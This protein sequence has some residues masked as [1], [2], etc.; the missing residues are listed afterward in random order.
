[1]AINWDDVRYRGDARDVN[2]LYEVYRV[3]DYLA[4]FE[5]NL[6]RQDA[7]IREQFLKDGIRLSR[8]L[9][10]RI[11]T[12]YQDLCDRLGTPMDVEIF[13]LPDAAVNAVAILDIQEAGTWSLVGVTAGA[14]EKL[15]DDE[16]KAILGH[17]VGHFLFGNHRLSA[18]RNTDPENPALTVLPVFGESLFL[19]WQKKAEISA[20][21]VGLLAC[22]NLQ[23]AARALLKATFGLS[24]RNINIDILALMTQIDEIRGHPEMMREAFSS[25][26]LLPVRLKA[27][28]SFSRSAKAARNGFPAAADPLDDDALEN[29]TDALVTLSRRYPHKRIG[30]A[31]MRAVALGGVRVLSADGDVS[32]QEIKILISLLYKHFTD[33]PEKEIVT[34]PEKLAQMLPKE[35]TVIREDGDPDDAGFVL[36]RLADVALADGAL[37][38]PEGGVILEIAEQLDFPVRSAYGILMQAAQEVG[39]QVDQKL[40]RLADQLKQSLTLDRPLPGK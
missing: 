37:L 21:R 29:E 9:S 14:L 24:D 38:E 28:E 20:D 26:P 10:P 35:L 4:A 33:E 23:A 19:R 5:E 17:E 18:L 31:V 36:S 11:F 27:L 7:G 1:M 22:G 25:H 34:D 32:E 39:F 40:N 13:C 3:K 12:L 16:L 15:D 8:T 6:R 2:E 30:E